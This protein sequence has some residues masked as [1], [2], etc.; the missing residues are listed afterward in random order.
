MNPGE[1]LDQLALAMGIEPEYRDFYHRI[2]ATTPEVK[3]MLLTAMG[4]SVDTDEAAEATLETYEAAQWQ[5]QIEPVIVVRDS[6]EPITVILTLSSDFAYPDCAWRLVEEQG[7]IHEGIWHLD[8]APRIAERTIGDRTYIRRQVA[9]HRN[10]PW[11]YHTLHVVLPD[12]YDETASSMRLIVVPQRCYLP[13]HFKT[14]G[15][16]VGVAIQLYALRSPQDGG[17]GDFGNLRRLAPI[18]QAHGIGAIG[19]NPLHALDPAHPAA[20]SPYSPSSRRL[21][22]PMYIDVAALPEFLTSTAVQQKLSEPDIATTL[23]LAREAAFIDYATVVGLKLDLLR[24]CYEEFRTGHLIPRTQRGEEFRAYYS[25]EAPNLERLWIFNALAVARKEVGEDAWHQWPDELRD[26][27]SQQVAAFAEQH[28]EDVEFFAYLEWE[29]GRQLAEADRA[30]TGM[31][32]G[33]YGDL[34]V[35]ITRDSAESWTLGHLF[36]GDVSVGA[37][38][39]A[40]SPAGQEW[41][42]LPF[43]PLA[44]RTDRYASFADLLRRNMRHH[45]AL[46]IDHVMTLLRLYWIPRG[47]PAHTGAYVR[48]PFNDLIG[49][50]A[51]ESHRAQCVI[52][53]EDLGVVPDGFRE[54][55]GEAGVLSYRLLDFEREQDGRFISADRYPRLALATTGTHDLAPL[56]GRWKGSDLDTLV[57][58]GWLPNREAADAE[59][60]WERTCLLNALLEGNDLSPEAAE[61]LRNTGIDADP[62]DLIVA[63]YH[64][65]ARTPALLIMV[66]ME[67]ILGL[68][69]AVNVPGTIDEQPNWRRRLPIT[70]EALEQNARFLELTRVM[71]SVHP[72]VVS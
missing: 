55:M 71:Q 72:H 30:C 69:T 44:L 57:Q 20:R 12:L 22:N 40:M 32:L 65:L 48:Y 47:A 7:A 43:S 25:H 66:Q 26:P 4:F 6:E 3:R 41:G 36:V 17:I 68:A 11:G 15:R 18:L 23:A 49:I 45:R 16:T 58:L 35:G 38:P 64:F 42:I 1:A 60:N 61:Y 63:A 67:D 19:L 53:G 39:D 51:L 8:D 27:R 5:R 54:H 29:A 33:L 70:I 62:H 31:S 56:A 50:L 10:L 28:R 24:L 13:D 21:I 52:V 9:I 59:R 34:A 37:P 14:G 46:R 2:Q